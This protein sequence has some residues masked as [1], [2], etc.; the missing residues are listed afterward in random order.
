VKQSY[1]GYLNPKAVEVPHLNGNVPAPLDDPGDRKL[2]VADVR[3][4]VEESAAKKKNKAK[5]P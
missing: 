4:R 2:V 1:G 5:Q 3:R